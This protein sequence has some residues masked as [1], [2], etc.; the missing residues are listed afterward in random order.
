MI[1]PSEMERLELLDPGSPGLDT[2]FL[3]TLA[4]CEDRGRVIVIGTRFQADRV[5]AAGLTVA[6]RGPK[7]AALGRVLRRLGHRGML[8]TW[9]EP[10]LIAAWRSGIAIDRVD[11]SIVAVSGRPPV[12]SIRPRD[13]IVVRAVGEDLGPRLFRRG[14]RLGSARSL[15]SLPSALLPSEP[16]KRSRI[17]RGELVV[18]IAGTPL[19][20]IDAR[21]VLAAAAS[22]VVAGRDVTL[23]LSPSHPHWRELG[24]WACGFVK[25]ASSNRLRLVVDRRVEDPLLAAPDVD[26][27]VMPVQ[28]SRLGDVSLITARAWLAAGVPIMASVTRG[29]AGLVDDGVDGRLLPVD[30]RNALARALLRV[31]DDTILLE[32]MSHAAA[33]RHGAR[34]LSAGAR[35]RRLQGDGSR[36]ANASAASR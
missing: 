25:A 30:D 16:P 13:Q 6:A 36:A 11:A 21:L 28:R 27:A 33:A 14:W 35:G 4:A 12:G 7:A 23:L 34:R 5:V 20:A 10:G 31:A 3:R 32:D 2:A 8:R 19:E 29:L 24:R 15:A 18:A 22:V 1:E 9:S 26:V 17:D